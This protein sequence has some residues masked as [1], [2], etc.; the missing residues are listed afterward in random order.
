M[1]WLRRLGRNRLLDVGAGLLALVVLGRLILALPSRASQLDFSHYYVS[2][3]LLL[4][5]QNPYTC[6]LEAESRRW[7]FVGFEQ[8]PRATN[9]PTLVWL[10]AAIAWAPP[11]VAF[12]S[13]TAVQVMSLVIVLGL[14]WWLM[15]GRL[16]GRAWWFLWAGVVSSPT[17][18]YHF[19]FS[20]V[21]LLL[22]ALVLGGFA[23]LQRG[24][25]VAACALVTAAGLLKLYPLLLLPWFLWRGGEGGRALWRRAGVT[26]VAGLAVV[27]ATGW[28]LWGDYFRFA[29]PIVANY[30][31]RRPFNFSIPSLFLN[32]YALTAGRSAS[33]AALSNWVAIAGA[34]GLM[35]VAVSYWLV[36]KLGRSL[37]A[38]FCLVTV[39]MLAGNS[40][41][42][43]HYFVFLIFP[44][45]VAAARLRDGLTAAHV[46]GFGLLIL[47]LDGIGLSAVN[48]VEQSPV[49]VFIVNYVP[50]V[51]LI[52]LGW[53][54]VAWLKTDP[55]DGSPR[56]FLGSMR[57][58]R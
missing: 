40:V 53:L 27:S 39:A 43:V 15:R 30:T 36:W 13:W 28:G 18:Y 41:V 22:A 20:Q 42:W 24:H 38:E 51:G 57:S 4:E 34:A 10:V 32:A 25:R 56:S 14:T 23:C 52:G 49:L 8:I 45:A 47:A 44:V 17:I 6:T 55:E 58:G 3:R 12:W 31:V 46:I 29:A 26:V 5:G 9:P 33:V 37:E 19:W 11:V 2:S 48:W 35:I 16:S 54:F 50:L 1:S 21:Q 7:G